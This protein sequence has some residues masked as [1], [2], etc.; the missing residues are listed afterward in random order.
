MNWSTYNQSLVKR[1]E[2]LLGFDVINNWDTELKEMNKDK[3]GEPFHYP[4]TFLLL[5]GYAKAYFHL[6]YRQTEGIA[7]GHA[8]GKLPSI[9]DFTTINRRINKLN[10]PINTGKDKVSKDEYIIIAIDSTGIKVTNRGQWMQDKWHLKN[11]KAYLKIHV[12]VNVKTKKILSMRITD[13][14]VHDSKALPELVNGVIESDKQITIGK[15]FA[16][17]AYD[18]NEIFRFLVDNGIQPCIKVRKNASVRWKRGKNILRNLS[19]LA[20][21]NDLQKWKGSVSYGQRWIVET[22]FSCLKRRFGE[23][24]YSVKL[25]NMIQEMMLKAS[26]YNKMTSV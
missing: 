8:K 20:Q 5:L 18:G 2:I 15:L 22:V 12:A 11:K 21:K 3:I 17:G 23:Y 14:Q 6:P 24:V 9:P 1:G 7:Q 13:E 10:I 19:V 16:D 26:L 25:Q 4:N